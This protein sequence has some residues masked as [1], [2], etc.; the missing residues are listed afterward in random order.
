LATRRWN[1][2]EPSTI[3]RRF[4]LHSTD[5]Q[6]RKTV[7]RLPDRW[8]L[9]EGIVKNRMKKEGDEPVTKCNRLKREVSASVTFCYRLKMGLKKGQ[10]QIVHTLHDSNMNKISGENLD[11]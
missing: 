6:Q 11:G 4:K 5:V 8:K 9:L 10:V 7:A 1:R 3:C 2:L